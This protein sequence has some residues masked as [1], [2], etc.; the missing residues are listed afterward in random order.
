MCVSLT[1]VYSLYAHSRLRTAPRVVK[2]EAF[3]PLCFDVNEITHQSGEQIIILHTTKYSNVVKQFAAWNSV[4]EFDFEDQS[5][6][7]I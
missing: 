5:A 3:Q 2:E 6:I 7:E 1:V 4:G